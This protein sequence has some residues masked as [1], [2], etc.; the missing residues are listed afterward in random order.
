[1]GCELTSNNK[2]DPPCKSSPKFIFFEKKLLLLWSTKL[3]KEKTDKNIITEYII[4]NFIFVKYSTIYN[5]LL[6]L[7]DANKL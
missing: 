1:M 4:N 7:G 3:F 6:A 5:Y 2:Y